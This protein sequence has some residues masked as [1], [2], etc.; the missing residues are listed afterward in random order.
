MEKH[1]PVDIAI[2][3][4]L[5]FYVPHPLPGT[6][7]VRHH[8]SDWIAVS[9]KCRTR[10]DDAHSNRKSTLPRPGENLPANAY[11]GERDC[12]ATDYEGSNLYTASLVGTLV[13]ALV[14]IGIV[15]KAGHSAGFLDI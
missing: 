3:R 14:Y 15:K 2:V 5:N 4:C 10:V 8:H 1:T 11:G 9:A 12:E 7:F 6:A 13:A